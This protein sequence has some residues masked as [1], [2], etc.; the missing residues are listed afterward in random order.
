[1][2]STSAMSLSQQLLCT[3]PQRAALCRHTA[4]RRHDRQE[5][6]EGSL[7]FAMN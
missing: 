3:T 2:G 5:V 1:M 7:Y 4:K 6:D